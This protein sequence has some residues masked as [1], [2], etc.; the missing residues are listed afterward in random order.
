[1]SNRKKA[2]LLMEL[3]Q[4]GFTPMPRKGKSAEP[5]VAGANDDISE[6]QDDDTTRE[7]TATVEGA[8]RGDYEYL[9]SLPIGSLTIESVQKLLAE[10]DEKEKEFE[11]LKATP[12]TSMWMKDLDELEK[13]LDVGIIN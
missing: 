2:D 4:K 10:K 1:M 3:Q 13:K 5:Q 12:P 9:L 8:K 11:I 6:E 7:E